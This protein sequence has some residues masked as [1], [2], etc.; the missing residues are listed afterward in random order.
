M[1]EFMALGRVSSSSSAPRGS[2][3]PTGASGSSRSTGPPRRGGPLALR[4]RRRRRE[5]TPGSPPSCRPWSP[6]G[7]VR[8]L[9]AVG[10]A[11]F[12]DGN[13]IE[14]ARTSVGVSE[15]CSGVRSLISCT[16]AGLFLSA[17]LVRR[18][19]NRAPRIELTL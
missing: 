4:Q 5:P 3:S 15:A 16:V 9:G 13:V 12:Q 17:T 1:A 2:A 14:L 8:V 11:A 18:P 7:V 10:I 6:H 19:L